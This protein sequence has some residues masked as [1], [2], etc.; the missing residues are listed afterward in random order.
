MAIPILGHP[1]IENNL[2]SQY[3]ISIGLFSLMLDKTTTREEI[4]RS[5]V[6]IS[7]DID[8]ADAQEH[9]RHVRQNRN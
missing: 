8:I 6:I 4:G 3:S 9:V 1:Y 5:W 2:S 7:N